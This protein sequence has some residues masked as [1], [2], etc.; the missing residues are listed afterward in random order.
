MFKDEAKAILDSRQAT[1]GDRVTNMEAAASMVEAYL[2][3][4]DQREDTTLTGADFAMIMALYKI[5]RF[6]VTPD[7]QDNI[8]DVEGYL[9]IVRECMGDQLIEAKTA[10][11]Y[12]RIKRERA[13]AEHQA[14]GNAEKRAE[15]A[16][17]NDWD[18]KRFGLVDEMLEHSKNSR[19]AK[20]FGGEAP[21]NKQVENTHDQQTG[22]QIAKTLRE[23]IL[24]ERVLAE[25][26]AE[27]QRIAEE[28]R[29]WKPRA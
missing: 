12:Q 5:Y 10:E 19:I 4:V 18:K 13:L 6:A 3:G 9:K 15:E 27:S 22:E 2:L 25:S 1:Y 16:A 8:D 23:G 20:L 24:K 14:S 29:I 11:E 17:M 21:V 26:E 7:Y 28:R